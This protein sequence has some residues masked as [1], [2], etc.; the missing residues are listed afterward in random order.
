MESFVTEGI[1]LINVD[2]ITD[3]SVNSRERDIKEEGVLFKIV[4]SVNIETL[5]DK[6]LEDRGVMQIEKRSIEE[7]ITDA[8]IAIIIDKTLSDGER[9]GIKERS[10]TFVIFRVGINT[11]TNKIVDFV[12]IGTEV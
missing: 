7:F 1:N 5:I 12:N 6:E 4:G 8:K 3:E 11:G 10:A 2:T 9:V